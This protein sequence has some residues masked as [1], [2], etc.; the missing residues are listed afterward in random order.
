MQP[1]SASRSFASPNSAQ[2]D[3]AS[4]LRE[5]GQAIDDLPEDPTGDYLTEIQEDYFLGLYWHSYHCT[6]QILDEAEFRQHYRS[7]WTGSGPRKPSALVDIVL[8]LCMQYGVSF[9]SRS[10]TDGFK[11]DV[12][13]TDATIAGRALYRRSQALLKNELESPSIF[14][15]QCHMFTVVY[16][17]NASFQNM[18]HNLLALAVRTAQIL[19]LHLEP[20]EDLPRQHKELRKR[21]WWTLYAVEVKT[22]MK[23]GRPWSVQM[24]DISCSLPSDDRDLVFLSG[25]NF[26]CIGETTW[27]TY[28]VQLGK[29]VMSARGVYVAF[30]DKCA[31]ILT[32]TGGKSLYTDP[33]SL[34]TCAEFLL[35]CLECMHNWLDTVPD[36]LKTKRKDGTAAFATENVC[37]EIERFAPEWLQRQRVL[38]ELLYH[39]LS[40]NL[41][42]PFICFPTSKAT[43]TPNADTLATKSVHHAM[44]LTHIM[45]QMITETKLL[46]G[47]H[48]AFQ[49]QWNA[50]LSMVGFALAYPF[51]PITPTVRDAIDTAIAVFEIMG[52]SFAV[53][54]SAANVTRDVAAKADFLVQRAHGGNAARAL[55]PPEDHDLGAQSAGLS[56][57]GIDAQDLP[58]G[59]DDSMG[60]AFTV[61]SFTSFEPV[62]AGN[63]FDMWTVPELNFDGF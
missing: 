17:C 52:K 33:T 53:A 39:N 45:Y 4:A 5:S 28:S 27:L 34:E 35:S 48:E 59:L 8:A 23:L 57:A 26:A 36:A 22:C 49:W 41:C 54:A 13:S 16:L 20:P 56:F 32:K 12:D 62:Y 10:E 3:K 51:R 30:F 37:L 40:M 61:D 14:T 11:T 9:L 50:A 58:A 43:V 21:L 60:L 55:S 46:N 7:L 15:L 31:D 38:L 47:W 24:A 1:N 2:P 63:L 25:S 44:A 19:G 6:Y 29:L 18:A 42:R